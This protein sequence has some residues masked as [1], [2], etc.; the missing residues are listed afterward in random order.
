MPK[1]IIEKDDYTDIVYNK[2]HSP[3]S[4]DFEIIFR[5][6]FYK[7]KII[8]NT[9][10]AGESTYFFVFPFHKDI[11]IS[12]FSDKG[13]INNDYLLAVNPNTSIKIYINER[14]M[15][16]RLIIVKIELIMLKSIFDERLIA[17]N[18]G[19]VIFNHNIYER[20]EIIN[21]SLVDLCREINER[22]NID[23]VSVK[24]DVFKL[25][26]SILKT[27]PNNYFQEINSLSRVRKPDERIEKAVKYIEE[28]YRNKIGIDE[29]SK[30]A[31]IS[32]YHFMKLFKEAV[33][34]KP[35]QYINEVKIDKAKEMIRN[36]TLSFERICEECGYKNYPYFYRN[37]KKIT[38]NTPLKYK[39]MVDFKHFAV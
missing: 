4:N 25:T 2:D 7:G 5:Y 11:N 17:M 31:C 9:F 18:N 39:Q 30:I 14:I 36:T 29:L 16:F 37:F 6:G 26:V 19:N 33:G 28:N 24:T 10:T 15:D 8:E 13:K 35:T 38:G 21:N 20:S 34:K 32:K 12:Y 27:C 23:Y 1:Q 22:E 3:N